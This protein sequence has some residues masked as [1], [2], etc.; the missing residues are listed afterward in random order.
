M[1]C[2]ISVSI[3][4]AMIVEIGADVRVPETSRNRSSVIL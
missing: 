3:S 2:I 4:F 1:S